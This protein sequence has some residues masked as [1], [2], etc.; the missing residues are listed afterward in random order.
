LPKESIYDLFVCFLKC[1]QQFFL[2][3]LNQIQN[4]KALTSLLGLYD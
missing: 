2:H 1:N 3:A 4:L